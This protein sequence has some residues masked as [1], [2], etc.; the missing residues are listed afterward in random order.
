MEGVVLKILG[1]V[2]ILLSSGGAGA[3]AS[4]CFKRRLELLERLRQMIYFLKGEITYSHAPL[5]EA[6]ERAGRRGKGSLGNLFL[7]V[8]SEI[9]RGQGESFGEIWEK[10]MEKLCS[11]PE[12]RLLKSQDIRELYRLGAHLSGC[13][14]AG[15]NA[16]PVS[17]GAGFFHWSASGLQA[18]A[19]QALWQFGN[20]GRLISCDRYVLTVGRR[21]LWESI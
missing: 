19:V 18:G 10:E 21:C 2:F 9:G 3:W 1:A 16:V 15:K 4:W 17:G 7:A 6:L 11:G 14:H 8:S 20:I 5:K 12:G 13:G